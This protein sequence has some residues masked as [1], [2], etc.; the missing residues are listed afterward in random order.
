M[1]QHGDSNILPITSVIW[2]APVPWRYAFSMYFYGVLRSPLK[3]EAKPTSH[4]LEFPTVR[5]MPKIHNF[6]P[7][8]LD[9]SFRLAKAWDLDIAFVQICGFS[10]YAFSRRMPTEL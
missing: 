7:Y 3:G 8:L 4:F 9:S 6:V 5:A 10:Y 1:I 2:L